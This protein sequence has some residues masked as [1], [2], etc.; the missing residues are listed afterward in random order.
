MS[1]SLTKGANVSL[2]RTDPGLKQ[3]AVGLG[4][5]A[6]STSG[7]EF[8]LDAIAFMVKEDGKVRKDE[9]FIFYNNLVSSCGSV[10]HT[11]DN[12]SGAG[13]GDDEVVEVNLTKVPADIAKVVFSV[14]IHEADARRQNFGMV[15]GA[16]IRVVNDERGTEIARFD[17]SEEASIETAMIFGEI[18]RH[19]GEWKFRAIGQGF[20][21]GLE[22]LAQSFGVNI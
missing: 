12:R 15:S 21:G 3:V 9:D 14:T 8:D 6:R 2:S 4:W 16:F 1:V 18:Y 11:G 7:D 5:N 19:S 13:D 17:L 20:R 22:A 10:K